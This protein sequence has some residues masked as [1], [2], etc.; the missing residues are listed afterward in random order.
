MLSKK[1]IQFVNSLKQKKYREKEQMFIAEGVKIVSELMQS[2]ITI[3]KV[4]AT[5]AFLESNNISQNLNCTEVK[6]NELERLSA[7]TTPN[8]VLAVCRIPNNQFQKSMLTG[9][10]TLALEDIKDP[11]NLGTIIRI[12][13]WFG[14]E[15]IICSKETV[16]AFN[17]KVVQATMGSIARINLFYMDLKELFSNKPPNMPVYGALLEGNNL[18]SQSLKQEGLIVIGNESKGISKDTQ[19]YLTNKINIPSFSHFKNSNGEAES[20]NAAIATAVIC[21]EFRRQGSLL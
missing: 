20:L 3:E 12:A 4:F 11:G 15:N 19:S 8:V 6:T 18:Y 7:L 16:D 9:K 21:S 5:A 2:P 14:I 10:I 1:D 17:P 13:D